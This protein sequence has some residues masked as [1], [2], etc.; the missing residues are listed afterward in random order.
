MENIQLLQ[1]AA[2]IVLLNRKM[3][4]GGLTEAEKAEFILRADMIAI[5]LSTMLEICRG[6]S[7]IESWLGS[8]DTY[9]A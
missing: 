1:H 6:V 2:A 5:E 7:E 9:S 3:R 4:K 8:H